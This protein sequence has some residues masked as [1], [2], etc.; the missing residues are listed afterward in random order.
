MDEVANGRSLLGLVQSRRRVEDAH[1]CGRSDRE[2][3]KG[4]RRQPASQGHQ[5]QPES[6]KEKERLS[7]KQ[8]EAAVCCVRDGTRRQGE[9]TPGSDVAIR[10]AATK[11]AAGKAAPSCE[12]RALRPK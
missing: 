4:K 7:R 6:A 8:H 11:E 12:Q 9:T 10:K 5:C 3:Q 1:V 2:D